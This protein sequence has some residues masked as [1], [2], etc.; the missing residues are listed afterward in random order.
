MCALLVSFIFINLLL[1]RIGQ[2]IGPFFVALLV[3]SFDGHRQRAYNF[4]LSGWLLSGFFNLL[5]YFTIVEDE[6]RLFDEKRRYYNH[7]GA[8]T[9]STC[10]DDD[11]CAEN[12][13]DDSPLLFVS[14]MEK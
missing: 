10:G 6:N 14:D 7:T 2:G 12:L 3:Q 11:D 1:S 13:I 5:I 8:T 9:R 4:A